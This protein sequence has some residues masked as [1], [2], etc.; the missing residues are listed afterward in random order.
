MAEHLPQ[1]KF[2]LY[3]VVT[4]VFFS[5]FLSNL[6]NIHVKIQKET[7]KYLNGD[8]TAKDS[9]QKQ[10]LPVIV[11]IQPNCGYCPHL[12]SVLYI[13]FT[14]MVILYIYTVQ[15]IHVTRLPI[16][17]TYINGINVSTVNISSCSK[18]S[19]GLRSPKR[20]TGRDELTRAHAHAAIIIKTNSDR[21][22]VV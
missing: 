11:S 10:C 7:E 16:K 19:N 8:T 14:P 13:P 1:I 22:S 20:M 3:T 15:G 5:F 18:S 2:F 21:K 6:H 9:E 17:C 4:K 12:S